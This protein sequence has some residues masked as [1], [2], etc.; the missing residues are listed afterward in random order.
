MRGPSPA[1]SLDADADVADG[2][3][4][5]AAAGPAIPVIAT[6][7]RPRSAPAPVGHRLGH[8]GGDG[9]VGLDQLGGHA[10]QVGLRLV[11]VGDHPAGDVRGRPGRLGQPRREQA[12]GARLGQPD[13]CA[14]AQQL[15][16]L[17]V[18]RAAVVGEQEAAVALTEPSM[19]FSRASSPSARLRMSMWSSPRRRQVVIS[20]GERSVSALDL[21]QG[22]GDLRL[23]DPEHPHGQLLV[24]LGP[25]EHG[26]RGLGLERP[27]PHRC[28]SRGGPG[29]TIT[30]GPPSTRRRPAPAR[31]PRGRSRSAPLRDHRL[32]SVRDRAAPPG[33][34]SIRSAKPAMIA[35][36]R[37]S[38]SSSSA[39]L[40]AGEAGHDLGGEVVGGRPEAAAGDDQVGSPRRPGSEAGLDV[41]GRSPTRGCGRPRPRARPGAG[42]STGRCGR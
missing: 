29:S 24:G 23:G 27:R 1:E 40:A 2:L 18:D 41:S 14:R 15:R 13:P 32:L 30:V 5:G 9:A 28:S 42:R 17:L 39:H 10:E 37:S 8:L 21:A 6:R 20:S 38:I 4:L 34:K 26:A 33:S 12:G 35:A 11:R 36:I 7:C 25:V 31:S 19:S 16:D 22:L 3:F